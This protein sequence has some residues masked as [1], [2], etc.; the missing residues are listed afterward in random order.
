MKI[1]IQNRK[2][3]PKIVV[4]CSSIVHPHDMRS[5]LKLALAESNFTEEFIDEVINSPIDNQTDN[6]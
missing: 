3:A 6:H 2:T 4:D 1:V 5:A